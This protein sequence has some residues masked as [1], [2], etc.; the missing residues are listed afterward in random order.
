MDGSDAVVC[1][2]A[3]FLYDSFCVPSE[4]VNKAPLC[5]GVDYLDRAFPEPAYEQ[6]TRETKKQDQE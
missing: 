2:V 6:V 1:A 3:G 4:Y 5:L